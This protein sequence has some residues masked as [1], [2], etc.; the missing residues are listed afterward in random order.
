[1][2]VP[3]SEWDKEEQKDVFSSMKTIALLEKE[4]VAHIAALTPAWKGTYKL[5]RS[6]I[7]Q[8]VCF[9]FCFVLA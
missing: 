9:L 1:M 3:P 6:V 4:R 2:F 7:M 8:V 5:L